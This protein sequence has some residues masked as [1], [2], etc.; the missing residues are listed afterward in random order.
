MT[1]HDLDKFFDAIS[2]NY[3]ETIERCFP[4]YREML[5]ALLNCLPSDNCGESILELGCGTGNLSML[6]TQVY[7]DASIHFVDLSADSLNTCRDRVGAE[8]RHHFANE[9]FRKLRFE[10]GKFDLVISSIAIHHLVTVEKKRLFGQIQGWLKPGGCF[11]YCDQFRGTTDEMYARH[12]LDLRS[13]SLQAG[14]TEDEFEMWM[15]HQREHDHHDTLPDQLNWLSQAG[16]RDV[17]CTWRYLLW[18]VVC[19]ARGKS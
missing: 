16:F 8:D 7:P 5:C 11:A 13:A 1:Q 15:R 17:D 6:L 12:I 18:S 4:R 19:A 9:D 2:G 3:T 14:S 10:D